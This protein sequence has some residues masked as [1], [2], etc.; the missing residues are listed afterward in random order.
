M[1]LRGIIVSADE[2]LVEKFKGG[3]VKR[4]HCESCW[5]ADLY[6]S[7]LSRKIKTSDT[8]QL[9]LVFT[10]DAATAGAVRQLLNVAEVRWLF[11]FDKYVVSD[12]STKK[13]MLLDAVHEA[14]MWLG[15]QRNWD[16]GVFEAC[17]EEALRRN[18]TYGGISKRSWLSPDKKYRARVAFRYALTYVDFYV[19]VFDRRGRELGV[20]P[21]GRTHTSLGVGPEMLRGTGKWG[22]RGKFRWLIPDYFWMEK[23]WSVDLSDIVG[24]AG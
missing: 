14:L 9:D 22:R 23:E 5:L 3:F 4:F 11:D 8:A 6:S 17:R 20:K 10:D 13:H 19:V 7:L 1:Y 15:R 21:L 24:K 12:D 16:V 18:L 2:E